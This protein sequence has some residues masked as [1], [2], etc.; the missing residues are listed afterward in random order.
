MEHGLRKAPHSNCLE[1]FIRIYNLLKT[2]YV[3]GIIS[4][5]KRLAQHHATGL[6]FCVSSP[7]LFN[8]R[9]IALNHSGCSEALLS[10]Y[11]ETK[12]LRL[13]NSEKFVLCVFTSLSVIFTRT[14]TLC[15]ISVIFNFRLFFFPHQAWFSFCTVLG[16]RA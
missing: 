14:Y 1:E 16:I 11:F 4:L 15:M 8:F 5:M 3:P 2:Y 12:N 6:L 9:L 13:E 7:V 10:S